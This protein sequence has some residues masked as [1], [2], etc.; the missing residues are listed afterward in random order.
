MWADNLDGALKQVQA[1]PEY[2]HAKAITD[3]SVRTLLG[4]AS[5]WPHRGAAGDSMKG[6]R[7]S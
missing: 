4:I 1:T 5:R 7:P 2:Q 6:F 3:L